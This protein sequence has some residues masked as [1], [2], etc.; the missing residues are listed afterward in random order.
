MEGDYRQRSQ[1][2]ERS[3]TF[4]PTL[5]STCLLPASQIYVLFIFIKDAN[6]SHIGIIGYN[7]DV[8]RLGND[9]KGIQLHLSFN[10]VDK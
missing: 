2:H 6:F 7:Y 8:S 10:R 4:P 1:G 5:P 9:C 3:F